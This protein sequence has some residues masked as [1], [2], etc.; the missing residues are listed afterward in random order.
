VLS[1]TISA[2]ES[3]TAESSY[4]QNLSAAATQSVVLPDATTLQTGW[5]QVVKA[6]GAAG[7]SVKTYDATTPVLLQTISATKAWEFILIDNST[8]AGSWQRVAKLD[9]EQL[10]AS[11]FTLAFNSTTDWTLNG[12]VYEITVLAS[13]HMKGTI[14]D[15]KAWLDNGTEYELGTIADVRVIKANGN[16]TLRVL[17]TPDTRF[18]G[19]L[20]I[21]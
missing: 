3:L 4:W 14:V 19:L 21:Q 8:A 12:S 18:A 7:L 5:C 10:Q 1:K 11:F 13:T 15:A 6:S 2:T 16:V 20:F 17:A 9:T